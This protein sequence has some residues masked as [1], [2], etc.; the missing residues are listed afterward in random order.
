M[1][2]GGKVDDGIPRAVWMVGRVDLIPPTGSGDE[3]VGD[4]GR[5]AGQHRRR[6]GKAGGWRRRAARGGGRRGDGARGELRR[7]AREA[8]RR[9]GE[10]G[11][12]GNGGDSGSQW[13][14]R[15]ARV[16]INRTRMGIARSLVDKV[17]GLVDQ[18]HSAN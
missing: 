14:G 9:A 12:A 8:A 15:D 17:A 4:G 16:A 5:R 2:L 1:D 10:P 11:A 7:P 3:A 18:D 13:R 6:P